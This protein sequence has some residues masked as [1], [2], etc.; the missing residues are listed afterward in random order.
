MHA[1]KT[2]NAVGAP[3]LLHRGGDHGAI[4]TAQTAKMRAAGEG[5]RGQRQPGADHGAQQLRP[6]T[7]A[8]N[9]RDQR[10][11]SKSEPVRD[12]ARREACPAMLPT[13]SALFTVPTKSSRK[14]RSSRKRL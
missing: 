11:A 12:A 7:V 3:L 5:Q 4:T 8:E 14:P 6:P 10:R 2:L 13:R 1:K 9:R